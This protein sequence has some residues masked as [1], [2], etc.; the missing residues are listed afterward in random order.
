[1]IFFFFCN[2]KKK[3]KDKTKIDTFT[4]GSKDVCMQIDRQISVTFL[5]YQKRKNEPL[6]Q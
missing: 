1:M 3:E 4:T 5:Q 6:K 2:V